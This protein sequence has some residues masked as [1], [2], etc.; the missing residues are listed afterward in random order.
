MSLKSVLRDLVKSLEQIDYQDKRSALSGLQ[1]LCSSKGYTLNSKPDRGDHFTSE[2]KIQVLGRIRS[3][4]V[5]YHQETNEI[6]RESSKMKVL[7]GFQHINM[8]KLY[9]SLDHWLVT[10]YIN[11]ETTDHRDRVKMLI[12]VDHLVSIQKTVITD[13]KSNAS[14]QKEPPIQCEFVQF[15]D[16]IKDAIKHGHE[17]LGDVTR[18]TA[19][20]YMIWQGTYGNGARTGMIVITIRFR[21]SATRRGQIP[22]QVAS[23]AVDRGMAFQAQGEF[24]TGVAT[25]R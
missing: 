3:V 16:N 14:F 20:A 22:G 7:K 25:I 15:L 5:K 1:Q 13:L 9:G 12:A 10:E 11:G 4:L 6:K 17:K 18:P 23:Y 2:V 24:R 19:M 21:P 8:P